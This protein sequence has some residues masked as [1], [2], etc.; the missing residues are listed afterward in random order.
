MRDGINILQDSPMKVVQEVVGKR[1][2]MTSVPLAGRLRAL[3]EVRRG[4]PHDSL[5]QV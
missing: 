3:R 2:S 4:Y 5:R 1:S